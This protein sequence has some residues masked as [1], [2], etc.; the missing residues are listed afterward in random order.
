MIK[1]TVL[2]GRQIQLGFTFLLSLFCMA[3]SVPISAQISSNQLFPSSNGTSVLMPESL[4][5]VAH[6]V[7]LVQIKL[8]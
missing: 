2:L 5:D 6:F 1:R 7:L 8:V 4:S 3:L